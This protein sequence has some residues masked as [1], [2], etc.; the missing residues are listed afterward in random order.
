MSTRAKL[1]VSEIAISE[2]NNAKYNP[3][4]ITDE[5]LEGL[6]YSIKTFGFVD[7]VIVNKRNMTIVGGHMRTRAAEALGY[8]FVPC[9]MVDLT[10]AEEKALNIALNSQ[11]IS[12]KYDDEILRPL[13]EEL[14]IT[15]DSDIFSGLRF[16]DIMPPIID[17]EFLEDGRDDSGPG[18]LPK[19]PKTKKGDIWCLGEHRLMCGDSTMI[20]DVEKLIGGH[21]PNLMVTDPPYGVKLDQSWRDK[22]LGDK[23]MGKGN[24]NLV[25][26][27]DRA[28]WYDAWALFPGNVCY[29]W[30]A[31]SFTDV[32][33]DSLRRANFEV[34][35]QIIWNKSVMIMG[36]SFYHWKHEPCWYSVKKGADH[37]WV[38]DRKQVTVWDIT[39]PNHIMGGSKDDKTEHPTQKPLEIYIKPIENHTQRGDYLYEPFG[40]SGTCV[41]AC[42]KTGRRSLTMELDTAY[43]DVIVKRWE[44]FTDKKAILESTGE[45]YEELSRY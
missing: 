19:Q 36:R 39:V 31:S 11:S 8:D 22:A 1:E 2:L 45:T 3:R 34:K 40:G 21:K 29:V 12:G 17:T 26:N 10:D 20:D 42:E 6:K 43:C 13:L 14:K 27:D 37:S 38:G 7:P 41:I 4:K 32:V 15:I 44:K 35:Q 9:T 25:Q 30:H 23:A 28:D 5:E 33:M 16:E 18:E 24:K